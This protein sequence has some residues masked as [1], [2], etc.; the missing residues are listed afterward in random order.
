MNHDNVV[1]RDKGILENDTESNKRGQERTLWSTPTCISDEDKRHLV[2]VVPGL[3][4][5][6]VFLAVGLQFETQCSM[7][8]QRKSVAHSQNRLQT[9][10]ISSFICSSVVNGFGSDSS[11][12]Q[13]PGVGVGVKGGDSVVEDDSDGFR[14]GGQRGEKP[15]I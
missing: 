5:K 14:C 3:R 4:Y 1:G 10:C 2:P 11:W 15:W 12:Q 6:M 9:K 7:T 8:N 13:G